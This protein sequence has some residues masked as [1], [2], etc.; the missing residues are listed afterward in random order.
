MSSPPPIHDLVL[1]G[2][3]DDR[4]PMVDGIVFADG[5]IVLLDMSQHSLPNRQYPE[6]EY[7]FQLRKSRVVDIGA[8]QRDSELKWT[9]IGKEFRSIDTARNLC[10][11]CGETSWGTE[12]FVALATADTDHPIWVAIFDGS[13]PFKAVTLTATTVEAVSTYENVW[14][15]PIETPEDVTVD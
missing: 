10:A 7:A 1:Q 3:R 15:F 2:W 8:L 6:K 5:H 13:N 4:C 9:H 12:G 11:W 14:S